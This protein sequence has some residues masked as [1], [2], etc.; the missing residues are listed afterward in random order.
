MAKAIFMAR[1][2]ELG[3]RGE[4][5]AAKHLRAEGYRLLTQNW[6]YGQQEIDLIA[7]DQAEQLL[8]FVEVKT[9]ST[10][11]F[12][13]PETAVDLKKQQFLIKAANAYL[14]GHK[15]ECELRFDVIAI[16]LKDQR[17]EELT[18]IKDAVIP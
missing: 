5:I 7:W 17:V 18:H 1:H 14:E 15:L 8:V 10:S 4:A 11:Y 3:K 9:R 6:R 12:G 13:Y 2:N 16:I